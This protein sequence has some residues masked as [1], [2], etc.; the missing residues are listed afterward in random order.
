MSKRKNPAAVALARKSVRARLASLT[1]EQRSTQ[2]KNAVLTRW[3]KAKPPSK[4]YGLLLLPADYQWHG[5]AHAAKV[6]DEAY[7]NPQVVLWSADRAEVVARAQQEDLRDR[8]TLVIEQDWD[9]RAFTIKH[10]YQ[11]EVGRQIEAL[12][13]LQHLDT[14]EVAGGQS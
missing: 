2:A 5:T 13:D 6:L 3:R 1:P 10:E 8:D 14:G 12:Q 9:P 11:P 7:A 4:W